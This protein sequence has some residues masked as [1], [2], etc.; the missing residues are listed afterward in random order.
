MKERKALPFTRVAFAIAAL[1]LS[2]L[3]AGFSEGFADEPISLIQQGSKLTGAGEIG[4]GRFG[5]S[6]AL[7]ADGDTALI[8][9]PRDGGEVGA[10]WTFTRS[11]STWVQQGE[12]LTGAGEIGEGHF[13]RGIALST[14]GETALVGA[15]N[16]SG[17]AGAVWVY[18]RSGSGW[19]QQAKLAGA[20]ETGGAWFGRS[21]ALSGD[22]ETALV[23]GFADHGDV[24]AVWVFTRSGSTWTQQGEKL[25]G[26]EELGRSE[27]G[28][29]VALSAEGDTAL[30]GGHGDNSGVGAVWVF[31]RSGSGW[32]QQAKLTGAEESG[33]GE[34][35]DDVALSADGNTALIGGL[36][37][38]GWVGAVWVFTRSGSTWTQLGTRL[39]GAGESGEGRFGDSVALS[40]DGDTALIGGLRDSDQIGAAWVFTRSDSTWAQREARLT[41]GEEAGK[42]EFGW[43]VALSAT[44]DTA[45][46]GG[47]GDAGD[48]G[49]A[50]VFAAGE[51]GKPPLPPTST[52]TGASPGETGASPGEGSTTAGG[53]GG[54]LVFGPTTGSTTCS[55]SLLSRK[56]SVRSGKWAVLKL[57]VKGTGRCGDRLRLITKTLVTTTRRRAPRTTTIAIGRFSIPAGETSS[58]RLKLNAAGRLLL[59]AHHG[60]LNV[61][62][63]ILRSS[64]APSQ[65]R[66]ETF[67]LTLQKSHQSKQRR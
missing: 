41:G 32:S 15:P 59:A 12:K 38:S 46:I 10:V 55:A 67:H 18:T 11:G 28:W 39:T 1:S 7:A 65:T 36:G 31:T 42:G 27:F 53:T 50:W 4:K 20:G 2:L 25:I 34:F 13:G 3:G 9:G 47:L 6:V 58:V 5:R 62:L 33:E 66:T 16:D 54:V 29:S 17:G 22:G 56:V 23:G 26:G 19:S 57:R 35:G 14:D 45:L 64:S 24:G 30:I 21:V 44:G 49:A 60:R 52:S 61:N 37:D 43:S 63:T 40:A 51:A 48:L 8:G